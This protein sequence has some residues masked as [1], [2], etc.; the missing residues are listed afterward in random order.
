MRGIA[1]GVRTVVKQ[2]NSVPAVVVDVH[3]VRASVQL[4]GNGALYR[5]LRVVGGP[6]EIGETVHVD[7]TTSEPTIVAPGKSTVIYA[8]AG[9]KRPPQSTFAPGSVT[10]GSAAPTSGSPNPPD[11]DV[12]WV[13]DQ[14]GAIQGNEYGYPATSG[15][16]DTAIAAVGTHRYWWIWLPTCTIDIG[17]VVN[18][19]YY[20]RVTG[21]GMH[22]TRLIG[23]FDVKHGSLFKDMTWEHTASGS[24]GVAETQVVLHGDC[25][26]SDMFFSVSVTSGSAVI[27]SNAHSVN[28]SADNCQF[29]SSH[30]GVWWNMIGERFDLWESTR[31]MTYWW[32]G[33]PPWYTE[34]ID[35]GDE[36]NY[37]RFKALSTFD[38]GAWIQDGFIL[39]LHA[40]LYNQINST[41]W[42]HF[43]TSGSGGFGDVDI[44]WTSAG[45]KTIKIEDGSFFADSGNI[46]PSDAT[47]PIPV[48]DETDPTYVNSY[49][50]WNSISRGDELIFV[51]TNQDFG[52]GS[53]YSLS[54][55]QNY[56]GNQTPHTF[57]DPGDQEDVWFY[58]VRG[59]GDYNTAP[60]SR[61]HQ[62]GYD[63]DMHLKYAY[64]MWPGGS[65][66]WISPMMVTSEFRMCS[67][68]TL[69][70]DII[71]PDHTYAK[72]D[73]ATMASIQS[74]IGNVLLTSD[75]GR[76][77]V[78]STEPTPAPPGYYWYK[79]W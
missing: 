15:G 30:I 42:L 78:S 67:F 61:R 63:L 68:A 53:N 16:L 12:I 4:A 58:L 39:G 66:L 31:F 2:G 5:N 62:N 64:V 38:A 74:Y 44:P 3:G 75:I 41:V 49:D 79:V 37:L 32:T 34:V 33:E 57:L 40:R 71:A 29:Y 17:G 59:M 47:P 76:V 20:I 70:Q 72:V 18:W 14:Y 11:S 22:S 23:Q 7:F 26:F 28:V 13:T 77:I 19:P 60:D 69:S 50:S 48:E 46:P 51:F 10:T 27:L 52:L 1:R 55:W 54:P 24:P 56:A 25:S 43:D 21:R 9:K 36:G 45:A 35:G 6:V 65:K 73:S 8:D